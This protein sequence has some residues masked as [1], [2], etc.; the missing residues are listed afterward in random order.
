VAYGMTLISITSSIVKGG[1]AENA[2]LD[3]E[4]L[5]CR[6]NIAGR[7]I[8]GLDINGRNSDGQWRTYFA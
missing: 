5:I 7:D 4:K 8:D 2:G 1:S 6:A 3:I